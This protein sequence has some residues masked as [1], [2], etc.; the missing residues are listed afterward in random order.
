MAKARTACHGLAFRSS[1]LA[2]ISS[3]STQP[4]AGTN[5]LLSVVMEDL[6]DWAAEEARDRKGQR[7]RWQ[8][9]ARLD[10]VDRLARYVQ[11][12]G[13]LALA[14]A[15]LLSQ[16]AHLV[17]HGCKATL[18]GSRCQGPLSPWPGPKGP[19]GPGPAATPSARPPDS[20]RLPLLSWRRRSAMFVPLSVLE[21][22]DRAAM[23]FGDRIG[24]IDGDSQFTY[25][26]FATRTHRLANALVELGVGAGDRV[27]FI[28]FNT[29]HL[30][31]AYYGVIEAGAVL[32]PGN[33]RLAPHEIAWIL[34]HA[35]S[36]VV[37]YHR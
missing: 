13:E 36:K 32:N 3:P 12:L 37:F 10:R 35:A 5:H 19:M 2:A 20:G 16:R 24:V 9:S 26:A 7:Q 4:K 21:F 14:Q 22:R 6:L 23:F 15:S 31:E 8:V 25:R 1:S 33:I 29:H 17:G 28:T 27:S 18:T 30:L 11:F 34:D